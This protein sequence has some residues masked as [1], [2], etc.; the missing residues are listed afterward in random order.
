M[1][2]RISLRFNGKLLA[3]RMEDANLE[4]ID[5][6]AKSQGKS[7]SE[8]MRLAMLTQLAVDLAMI[9][10]PEPV[11]KKCHV[12]PSEPVPEMVGA[13]AVDYGDVTI[14]DGEGEPV[15]FVPTPS[16]MGATIETEYYVVATEPEPEVEV[17][18]ERPNKW[19]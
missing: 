11:E 10:E 14:E 1:D 5:R 12:E 19:A 18:V 2:E 3:L 4:N 6:V 17:P 8:W 13:W 15:K 9:G 7:R 16:R